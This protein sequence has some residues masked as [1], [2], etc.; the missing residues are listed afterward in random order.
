MWG[1]TSGSPP[2]RVFPEEDEEFS[3]T[4][5]A[6]RYAHALR[7]FD[8]AGVPIPADTVATNV[9]SKHYYHLV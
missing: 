3:A 2:E 8:E 4:L 9:D 5:K 6:G 7:G 1:S